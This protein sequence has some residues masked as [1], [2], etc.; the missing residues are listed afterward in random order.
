MIGGHRMK[1]FERMPDNRSIAQ[2]KASLS[3]LASVVRERLLGLKAAEQA[4]CFVV[5]S[6]RE[7][8]RG[9]RAGGRAISEL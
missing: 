1:V 7:K 5:W 9:Y 3:G 2:K 6:G 4:I 8:Q